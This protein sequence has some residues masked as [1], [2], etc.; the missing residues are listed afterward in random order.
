MI[1]IARITPGILLV[2][3]PSLLQRNYIGDKANS[4]YAYRKQYGI[5]E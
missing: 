4:H 2:K 5:N 3:N 1:I